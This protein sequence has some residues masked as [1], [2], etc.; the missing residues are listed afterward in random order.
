MGNYQVLFSG[1]VSKQ[2]NEETVRSNL[3]RE[4]GIDDLKAEQLFSGRTVVIKSQL[5]QEEALDLQD[6]FAS[7]GAVCR[8]KDLTPKKAEFQAEYKIDKHAGDRTMRDITAAHQECPRCGY[9]QLETSHCARCG[10]DI[11]ATNRAKHKEDL[12]IQKKIRE[13]RAA[14]NPTQVEVE[15]TVEDEAPAEVALEPEVKKSGILSWFK[16]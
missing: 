14:Q 4:L 3:A 10:V 1:E 8:V 7:L 2:A 13:H 15:V 16:K 6:K 11:A 12:I 5:Q 9:M